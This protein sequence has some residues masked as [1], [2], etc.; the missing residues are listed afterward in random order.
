M[1]E[2]N[3]MPACSKPLL[4]AVLSLF[5]GISCGQI[6]LQRA[7]IKVNEYYAS[8][9]DKEAISIAKNNFVNTKH[10][11]SVT[12]V[13]AKDLPKIKLIMGGSPCQGFSSSGKGLNFEDPRS[14]LFF[15]FV[16]LIKECEPEYFLL[17]N[18]KM[19]KEYQDIITEH[20]GVEPIEI[21]S[22]LVSAQNRKR[23]YWTNIP[24]VTQ[25]KD[26]GIFLKDIVEDNYIN[27][28]AKRTRPL[29]NEGK[30]KSLC[31]E[32]HGIEKSMCLV[33]VNLNNLL[34]PLPRGKYI[35]A[36]I[37][38]YPNRVMNVSEMEK[39]QTVPVGYVGNISQNKAA[40]VLGN[41]WT[42]DVIAHILSFIPQS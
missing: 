37:N 13:F 7:G 4:P 26:K 18:V 32:V 1:T 40:K 12:D 27:S 11:G 29:A 3:Q 22:N 21:N 9:I 42:V 5:D 23:I 36:G 16:R 33:T 2:L 14:K 38:D 19:K 35:D 8:E 31:L 10:I 6:A 17:E 39:L 24:N 28:A 25:P 20:L 30:R 41:G 34:S 15:E